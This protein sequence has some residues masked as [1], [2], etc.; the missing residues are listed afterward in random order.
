MNQLLA[1]AREIY[2]NPL[3]ITGGSNTPTGSLVVDP[4]A[5]QTH[6]GF[7]FSHSLKGL[8]IECNDC[9]DALR[10]HR[11]QAATHPNG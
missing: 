2:G 7:R 9:I 4:A 5:D 11:A 10:H 3:V 8:R 1:A 6:P